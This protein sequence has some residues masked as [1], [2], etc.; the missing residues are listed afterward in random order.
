MASRRKCLREAKWLAEQMSQE[1]VLWLNEVN[2]KEVC[3]RFAT[4]VVGLS[5][6]SMVPISQW[7]ARYLSHGLLI[8]W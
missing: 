8:Y 3:E 5:A 4:F 7:I 1:A 6:Y 2:E